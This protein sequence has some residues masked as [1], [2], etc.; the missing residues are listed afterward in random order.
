M[1]GIHP[2]LIILDELA[3]WSTEAVDALV[4]GII[5]PGPYVYVKKV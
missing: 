3:L 5:P 4:D 2:D 1:K